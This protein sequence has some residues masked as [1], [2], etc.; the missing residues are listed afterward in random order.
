MSPCSEVY[1]TLA[2][3][4][5]KLVNL[6]FWYFSLSRGLRDSGAKTYK[7]WSTYCFDIF[8]SPEVYVTLALK[9]I[10]LGQLT[11]LISFS[12]QRFTWLWR[13]L[14]AP[15]QLSCPC[16]TSTST[17]GMTKCTLLGAKHFGSQSTLEVL[18]AIYGPKNKGPN[19]RHLS[20]QFQQ[21]LG[22]SVDRVAFKQ[23]SIT[24]DCHSEAIFMPI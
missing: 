8:L 21:Q 7:T 5:I 20:T 11:V 14:W 3:K 13:C 19:C 23:W 15:F 2:L 4:H 16:S 24:Q 6:L 12:L 10:K 17:S 1:V 22:Y 18:K 9:R